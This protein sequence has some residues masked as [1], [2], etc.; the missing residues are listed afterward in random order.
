MKIHRQPMKHVMKKYIFFWFHAAIPFL[1]AS[2]LKHSINKFLLTASLA[3][4][5]KQ[6]FYKSL[7][8]FDFK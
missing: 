5:E 7:H 6:E 4:F 1:S 8:K 3:T 2:N